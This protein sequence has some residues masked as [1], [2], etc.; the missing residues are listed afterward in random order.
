MPAN[1][2]AS[3]LDDSLGARQ[4]STSL[5]QDQITC[6]QRS[7]AAKAVFQAEV[8]AQE[9]VKGKPRSNIGS[10]ILQRYNK[11]CAEF[12]IEP[13]DCTTPKGLVEFCRKRA[14]KVTWYGT[15]L[16]DP[17]PG[18]YHHLPEFE[19]DGVTQHV[20]TVGP[21][22]HSDMDN[23][24]LFLSL[25]TTYHVTIKTIWEAICNYDPSLGKYVTE[26]FRRPLS[27][28]HVE[29]RICMCPRWLRLGLN[30]NAEGIIRKDWQW[31]EGSCRNVPIISPSFTPC[32]DHMTDWSRDAVFTDAKR[33]YIQPK[34]FHR[35]GK[36]SKRRCN[37]HH[38]IRLG[39]RT[40]WCLHWYSAISYRFGTVAVIFVSGTRGEGYTA[41][42]TYKVSGLVIAQ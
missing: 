40:P 2:K 39:I 10:T 9:T 30:T 13:M 26:E 42:K 5:S 37:V 3:L 29:L 21:R 6:L 22:V 38:D 1:D 8:L 36:R 7:L 25:C 41:P 35:Y 15:A 34:A 16:D 4:H 31:D 11:L 19:I 24:P 32:D 17:K 23:D 18:P 33:K 14:E 12:G 27:P 28:D 20:Y